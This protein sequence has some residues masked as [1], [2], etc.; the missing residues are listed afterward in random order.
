MDWA[1][2]QLKEIV[3]EVQD[4]LKE[5]GM[6]IPVIP[7]GGIFTGTEAASILNVVLRQFRLHPFQRDRNADPDDAKQ[8]Y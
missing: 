4:F 3:I 8:K 1:Q 7:A 2:Y 5:N 6:E